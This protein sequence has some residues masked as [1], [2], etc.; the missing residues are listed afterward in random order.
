LIRIVGG[1]KME[2]PRGAEQGMAA[3]MIRDDIKKADILE[4]VSRG[5][6]RELLE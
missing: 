1:N 3:I 2:D 5:K 4:V 6:F